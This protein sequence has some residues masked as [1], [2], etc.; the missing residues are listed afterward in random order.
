MGQISIKADSGY[1]AL[2]NKVVPSRGL[3][4]GSLP[5]PVSHSRSQLDPLLVKLTAAMS[6]VGQAPCMLEAL[7][8]NICREL[9]QHISE[10]EQHNS[11]LQAYIVGEKSLLY[12]LCSMHVQAVAIQEIA[13]ER[14]WCNATDGAISLFL[15]QKSAN[16]KVDEMIEQGIRVDELL[17]H[18]ESHYFHG[19]IQHYT[20][21]HDLKWLLTRLLCSA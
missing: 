13:R 6:K 5:T 20:I 8:V 10:L 15:P 7:Y 16:C 21:L 9:L 11:P 18:L 4:G 3:Q 19:C 12:V 14:G 2:Y 17:L 1:A